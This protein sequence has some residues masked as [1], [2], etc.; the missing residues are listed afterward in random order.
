MP[1][2]P[3]G[4]GPGFRERILVMGGF[5]TGKTTGWLSAARWAQRTKADMH[6]YVMDSDASVERMIRSPGSQY[7]ELDNVTTWDVY[8]WQHYVD[9]VEEILPK[10]RPQDWVVCDFI[11]PSWDA[12]QEWYVE[13]I[14]GATDM[15]SYFMDVRQSKKKGGGGLEGWKD[16]GVINRVYK[17]W[18][19]KLVHR[20]LA[21]TYFTA[22]SDTIRDTDVKDVKST[23]GAFGVRPRGQK[24]LAFGVH[25]VLYMQTVGAGKWFANT[26]KDREREYLVSQELKDFTL[27]YLVK[28]GGWG[29]GA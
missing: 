25:T 27:D 19:N 13:Q 5:G 2:H 17:T 6:F 14:Y 23:F 29:F 1:L 26:V 3:P 8:E 21:H 22:V 24:H 9:A 12:V 15:G 18:M 4:E 11:G 20:N 7:Q 10:A 28:V 16:Y